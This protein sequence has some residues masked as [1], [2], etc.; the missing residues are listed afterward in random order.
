MGATD[1]SVALFDRIF[2]RLVVTGPRRPGTAQLRSYLYTAMLSG[3][4]VLYLEVNL[5]SKT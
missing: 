4:N 2:K 3:A 5:A 1:N